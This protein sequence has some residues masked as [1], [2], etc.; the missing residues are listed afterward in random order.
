[1]SL[2][3]RPFIRPGEKQS[4]HIMLQRNMILVATAKTLLLKV[5]GGD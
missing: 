2:L 4:S 5:V 1:M 3:R